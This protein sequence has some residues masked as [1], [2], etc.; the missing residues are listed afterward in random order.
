MRF[1]AVFSV[2][3]T[4]VCCGGGGG[5]GGAGGD[6]RPEVPGG[7]C[8]GGGG[9]GVADWGSGGGITELFKYA[10]AL[11]VAEGGWQASSVLLSPAPADGGVGSSGVG[12]RAEGTCPLRMGGVECARGG[13]MTGTLEM[14]VTPD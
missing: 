10:A 2:T 6:S 7:K 4:L 13:R 8:G 9:S 11:K 5:G 14:C 3:G 12:K 1:F